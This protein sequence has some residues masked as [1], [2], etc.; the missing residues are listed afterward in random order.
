MRGEPLQHEVFQLCCQ[1]HCF[2]AELGYLIIG[3]NQ[4]EGGFGPPETEWA[5]FSHD[6]ASF[7]YKLGCFFTQTW[8][9]FI[10]AQ[11]HTCILE[12]GCICETS[13]V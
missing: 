12:C 7:E 11:N 13:Q 3:R 6:W 4:L 9:P 10:S 1:V 5:G 2:P 8:Q